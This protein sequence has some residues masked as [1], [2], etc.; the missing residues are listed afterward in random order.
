MAIEIDFI[1]VDTIANA[2]LI[3]V[4]GVETDEEKKQVHKAIQFAAEIAKASGRTVNDRCPVLCFDGEIQCLTAE[5]RN[6]L[7]MVL[8]NWKG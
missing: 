7:L 5:S 6:D 2:A 8:Q 1:S 4:S 3:V